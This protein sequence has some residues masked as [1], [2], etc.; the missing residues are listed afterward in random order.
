MKI[1]VKD[2][3]FKRGFT[4]VEMLVVVAVLAVLSVAAYVGI[5][6]TQM[7]GMNDKVSSDLLAIENALENYK[8]DQG[9]Y[10]G[11]DTLN[12]GVEK[13]VLCFDEDKKY[14][15][16]CEKASFMQTQIDNVLLTKRYLQDL[17]LD[18]RSGTHYSYAV[19]ADGQYYQ[20]AGLVESQKGVWM[21]KMVG[22][23]DEN[24]PFTTMIRAY[25]GPRFVM[26]D[27]L[28]LPY[29]PNP[30][31]ITAG[32]DGVNGNVTINTQTAQDGDMMET[33]DVIKTAA[34]SSAVLYLS[35]GSVAHL[36]PNSSL[37]LLPNS[38][39]INNA[40]KNLV[41]KIR[42]KLFE[43]NVWNKVVRLAEK[44]EFNV[45]T[46]NAIAGVRGTEF[47]IDANKNQLTIYSGEVAT[48]LKTEAEKTESNG[49]GLFLDFDLTAFSESQT[50]VGNMNGF[51]RYAIPSQN[52]NVENPE[53]LNPNESALYLEKYYE[54][55]DGLSAQDR[56][57]IVKAQAHNDG[58]Y[59][60]FVTMNGLD[61]FDELKVSGFEVYGDSQAPDVRVLTEDAKPLLEV[62]DVQTSEDGLA[63][64]FD[65]DYKKA[66]QNPL[67]I[68]AEDRMESI[69]IKALYDDGSGLI[70]SDL[71]WPPIG[72]EPNPN[73][74]YEYSFKNKDFYPDLDEGIDDTLNILPMDDLVV[75]LNEGE[76][77]IKSNLPC[78]WS[79]QPEGSGSFTPG[80]VT[81]LAKYMPIDVNLTDTQTMKNVQ[82]RF[83]DKNKES[84]TVRCQDSDDPENFDEVELTVLY[85]PRTVSDV[86]EYSYY[87][88][89]GVSWAGAKDICAELKEGGHND[90]KVP[91]KSVYENLDMESEKLNLCNITDKSCLND[92]L[93]GVA[94]FV[95]NEDYEENIS[96]GYVIKIDDSNFITFDKETLFESFAV[97][98][99]R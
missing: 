68:Q 76:I 58:T 80:G 23:I 47:G 75:S 19:S 78:F 97:R 87:T 12:L 91:S 11:F 73:E 32:L 43:G 67:F 88:E 53:T 35:D 85:A 60:I 61:D 98:C 74:E 17:P 59:S 65:L 63:Y 62:L 27:G 37:Q 84:I 64:V 38:E 21:S 31:K 1:T 89:G 55:S 77:Q 24:A 7:R 5:Q 20:V 45:E 83:T 3:A 92:N 81:N 90:W 18:P 82:A 49:D 54:S 13:N 69:I 39:A 9:V 33:G 96:D 48:R 46:T 10:P 4:L 34:N 22:N 95:L 57:Y 2:M 56:P 70:R 30:F 66:L 36:D 93:Q 6:V 41:T 52:Q 44:S 15:H 42:M 86:Y 79:V 26:D 40:Q 51:L 28:N 72:L 16:L 50:A 94:F 71:S 99:I 14:F 25:D 29:S 8:E